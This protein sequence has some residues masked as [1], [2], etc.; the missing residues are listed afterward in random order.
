MTIVQSMKQRVDACIPC[1][2]LILT[3]V[4]LFLPSYAW[5]QIPDWQLNRVHV[6]GEQSMARVAEA[7]NGDLVMVWSSEGADSDETGIVMRRFQADGT[8]LALG[9]ELVNEHMAGPQRHPDLAIDGSGE[10]VVVWEGASAVDSRG[11][12]ARRFAADGSPIGGEIQVDTALTLEQIRPRV[13]RAAGGQFTVAWFDWNLA[14]VQARHFDA[15]G[16]P[17]ADPFSVS[18]SGQAFSGGHDLA[19]APGGELVIVWGEGSELFVRRWATDGQAIGSPLSFAPAAE[20]NRNPSL[21]M[22][23][24][25]HYLV[26]WESR[27]TGNQNRICGQ[28]FTIDDQPLDSHFLFNEN[29]KLKGQVTAIA[30]VDGSF[31]AVWETL[32]EGPLRL[33]LYSRRLDP[34]GVLVGVA[35][36]LATGTTLD[37]QSLPH[38]AARAAGGSVLVWTAGDQDG[39]GVFTDMPTPAPLFADGFESGDTTHWYQTAAP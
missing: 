19:Y 23:P 10:M 21:A 7:P 14:E 15:G 38:L 39:S 34:A 12:V 28:V 3:A 8:P 18:Q 2:R 35:E 32:G 26:V 16:V 17:I 6:Q 1:P 31:R 9:E 4:S 37:D 30:E 27:R 20:I 13:V 11:I 24:G 29:N 36:E 22:A 5:A 25:G 33:D